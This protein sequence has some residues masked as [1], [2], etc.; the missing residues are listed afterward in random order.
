[1][2]LWRVNDGLNAGLLDNPSGNPNIPAEIFNYT[3]EMV[4]S[5]PLIDVSSSSGSQDLRVESVISLPPIF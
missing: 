2:N 4:I 1:M 5:S 3:P